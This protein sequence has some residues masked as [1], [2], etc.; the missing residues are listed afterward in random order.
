[1]YMEVEGT[2]AILRKEAFP[3][4]AIDV[5]QKKIDKLVWTLNC[6][7]SEIV[8]IASLMLEIKCRSKYIPC[9]FMPGILFYPL[10]FNKNNSK[11]K[12][13]NMEQI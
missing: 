1:M 6:S 10:C 7:N 12:I 3:C 11:H 2:H 4:I 5:R 8:A 13:K 9:L